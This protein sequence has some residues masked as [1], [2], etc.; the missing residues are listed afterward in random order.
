MA[1][2]R[3]HPEPLLLLLL[4]LQI[5]L[6]VVHS[7]LPSTG[8]F[9]NHTA[10]PEVPCVP[11]H[12]SALL[13]LKRSFS[14]TNESI[15]AFG[16]WTT[17]TDCCGWEGI[18]C[19]GGKGRVTFLDLSNLGL[20]SRGLDP[21]LFDLTSLEHLNLAYNDFGGSQLPSN[22]F[23]RLLKLTHLNLSSS[24]FDGQVPTGIRHLTNLVSLDLSTGFKS[25]EL[26][27]DGY[28]LLSSSDYDS[29]QLVE[30]NFKTLIAKLGN[31]REIKLGLVDLSDN[32]VQ[33]CDALAKSTPKIRL[34]SLPFCKL[35][36]P[37]CASLSSLNSLVTIDLGYNHLSGTVPD[38]LANFSSLRVLQLQRN[39]LEGWVSPAIFQHKKL[40]TINLYHNLELYGYLPNFSTSN[41]LENLVVGRTKFY[42]TIPSSIGNLK[43]LK[44]L[45]LSASGFSGEL[46]LSIRKLK[47]LNAIEISGLGL[48]GSVPSWVANL[49]SLKTLQFSDCGLS[50]PI[51]SFIG[52]LTKL[53]TLILCNSSFSGEIPTHISNLTQLRVLSLYENNLFGTVELTSLR[54]LP[55][56]Y[57]FDISY[58]NLVVVNGEDNSSSVS[59][60][61]IEILNLAGCRISEFPSFLRYQYNIGSLDL[62]DNQI[63]GAI[64]KWVWENWY[65]LF[66]LILANNKFTNIGYDPLLPSSI[67]VFDLSNNMFQGPLPIPRG[68]AYA[69]VYSRNK[70]SSIPSNFSSHLSDSTLLQVSE[71]NFSGNIPSSFCEPTSIQILDI[72]YNNF[73]GSIPPCLM[74]NANG[75]VSLNLKENQLHGE[76]P[77]SF[78]D[79][80]S[81]E[82]LDLSGN[83][84]EGQLPR[85]LVACKNLQILDVGNNIISDSFPCWMSSLHR[86]EVLVLKS[87]KLFGHVA[88]SFGKEK[89]IA[90]AFPSVRIVDLSSNYFSG[91][92]PQ[93][94]WFKKLKSMILRDPNASL[95]MDHEVPKT[96]KSY[97]YTAAITYKGHDTTFSQI[98]RTLVFID[99]SNNAFI[100]AIPKDIGELVLLHGL[101]L[102][103]N[104][105]TGVIPS[106]VSRLNQLEALDL[107]SNELSGVIPHEISSL[108]FLTMLNLSYNKL[109]GRIPES[110]HFL[111]FSNNS[112]L[113]NDGLCGSPLSKECSNA[114]TPN[115]APHTAKESSVDIMLFLFTGLGF[116]VGFAVVIVVTWV[117]PRKKRS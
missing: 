23:E 71:N 91:P 72:S 55:H 2:V 66:L 34:L 86:L 103:H 16:S 12:A 13:R 47:S 24:S 92:L 46:P 17:G 33:W 106:Q 62:S 43:S 85:S 40:V 7:L 99:V 54:K 15:A 111:T 36:G 102:S 49:T 19:R 78:S 18:R 94:R 97:T 77:D 11:D 20:Q 63:H 65:E 27:Q 58:N 69:L 90:C 22:G 1:S 3:T 112:F 32:G 53:E 115:V 95:I 84:I 64:P 26:L 89:T 96:G 68:S 73:N 109:E 67:E 38:F 37:I 117:L 80:C 4:L 39:K 14:T 29:I 110:P 74:E 93:D 108:D 10:I 75:M 79:G 59:F 56:L 44:R 21:S 104:F 50:G 113:G 61:K 42:G 48:V 9:I 35:T 82:A 70:F 100:G 114:T 6:M 30:P 83:L 41:S 76:F 52:D 81:F 57:A 101:N 60:P 5:H 51:P 116:G 98:L 105:L 107:S 25:V 45:G 28:F 88:Q 8:T 31:L 87:N